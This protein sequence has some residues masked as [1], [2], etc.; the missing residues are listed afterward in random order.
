VSARM[1]TL[2]LVAV[3]VVL[4][5]SLLAETAADKGNLHA[6]DVMKRSSAAL[7]LRAVAE[8]TF[9]VV[10]APVASVE[11]DAR[12]TLNRIW[13]IWKKSLILETLTGTPMLTLS[14]FLA[15][16]CWKTHAARGV[17]KIGIA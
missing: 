8:A 7:H 13:K 12:V 2:T 11:A 5:T 17:P 16:L 10:F 1:D 14:Q 9:G 15:W 4:V 3:D 6:E